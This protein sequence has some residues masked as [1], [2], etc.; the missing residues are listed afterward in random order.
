ML[1]RDSN[2]ETNLQHQISNDIGEIVE[3]LNN[4]VVTP[5]TASTLQELD[6]NIAMEAVHG[7][8]DSS[9]I[10]GRWINLESDPEVIS[11]CEV[12][13]LNQLADH[14]DQQATDSTFSDELLSNLDVADF[15]FDQPTNSQDIE[16][17]E[18]TITEN[19]LTYAQ[20]AIDINIS[21]PVLLHLAQQLKF[22]I[23]KSTSLP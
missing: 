12:L 20:A 16:Q 8:P 10:I 6:L 2:F 5:E 13:Q 14:F 9:S 23:Q 7:V 19:L 17:D 22:H 11:A 4:V 18:R 1:D 15:A 3:S 21:D